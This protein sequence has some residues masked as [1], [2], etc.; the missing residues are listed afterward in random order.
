MGKLSNYDISVKCLRII[1]KIYDNIKSCVV[2]NDTNTDFFISNIGIRHGENLSP[3]LL[4]NIFLNDLSEYFR[5]K[6]FEGI[7][8][9]DHPSDETL[10]VYLNF[11]FYFT[12]TIP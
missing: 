8:I 2:V 5:I 10:F 7:Y 4:F 1:K 9:R 12:Q 11:L 6:H 3:L